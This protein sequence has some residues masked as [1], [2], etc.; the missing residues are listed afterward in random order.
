M[1][2]LLP[3]DVA[4]TLAKNI[5]DT[6]FDD[7][8]TKAVDAAKKSIIDTLGVIV[9]ASGTIPSLS[10]LVDL[11]KEAGGKPESTIIAFGGKVPAWMAAFANGA[12][13]HC[14]DYDDYDWNSTYHPSSAVVPAGFAIAERNRPINGK[15]FI[16][17]IALGQ[18]L[19]IR[20]ALAIPMERKPPWQRTA[21]LSIFASVATVTKLL[22]LDE[23]KVVDAFGIA[24]CQSAGTLELRKGVG[25]DIG[26]MYPAFPAKG[27]VLS[28]LLAQ[29][30]VTGIKRCFEGKGGLFNV[31]FSRWDRETIIS[32]LG[33]KFTGAHISLKAWPSCAISHVYIDATLSLVRENDIR[34]EDIH[35]IV[36]YVGDWAQGPCEPLPA[37]QKPATILD[38]KGSIPF[39]VAV[40][41]LRRN[42]VLDD[43]SSSALKD[44]KTLEMAEKVTPKFDGRL[45]IVTGAPPGVVEIS[46][47]GGGTFHKE[48]KHPYGHPEN[49]ITWEGVKDKFRD[50]ARYA[51]NDLLKHNVEKVVELTLQLEHLGDVAEIIEQL[52]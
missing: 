27:G 34:P 28:A 31:Y 33:S 13:A 32:D 12:M 5:V 40:A 49:P 7:L 48:V 4:Y 50:C 16:T 46:T 10:G 44:P 1:E 26:G 20:L 24:L 18:D 3:R 29:R 41:A 47:K 43:F 17:A 11:V 6:E 23:E 19:G 2:V 15:E 38:A 36:V 35:C 42:V 25:T 45:N 14:L 8:P 39:C 9:G 37:R 22:K 51:K 21:V 52:A 30:G